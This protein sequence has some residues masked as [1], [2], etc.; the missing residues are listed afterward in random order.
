LPN[1]R[2]LASYRDPRRISNPYEILFQTAK[3]QLLVFK[4]AIAT[5]ELVDHPRGRQIFRSLRNDKS[6]DRCVPMNEQ[7]LPDIDNLRW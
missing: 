7:Q 1:S 5:I 6:M 3:G 4:H 2:R